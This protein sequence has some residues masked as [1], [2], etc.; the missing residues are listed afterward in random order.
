MVWLC[1]TKVY[2]TTLSESSV[3]MRNVHDHVCTNVITH[4]YTPATSSTYVQRLLCFSISYGPVQADWE[5]TCTEYANKEWECEQA[6][7]AWE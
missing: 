6:H 4:T 2:G 5:L 3:L 1:E 7:K